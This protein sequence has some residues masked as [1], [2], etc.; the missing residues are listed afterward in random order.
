MFSMGLYCRLWKVIYVHKLNNMRAAILLFL[1]L[2]I[3]LL[4]FIF[5]YLWRENQKPIVQQP[6]DKEFKIDGLVPFEQWRTSQ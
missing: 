1:I 6:P 5:V 3:I 4:G 2:I